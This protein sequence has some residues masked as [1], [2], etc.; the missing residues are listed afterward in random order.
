LVVAA[1]AQGRS[2]LKGVLDSRDTQVMLESLRALGLQFVHDRD[3]ATVEIEG[4]HG[5]PRTGPV[6]L[7]LENSGTSLRFLTAVCCLGYGR[8]RLDGNARMR[9]RPIG[10][11][12]EALCQWGVEARCEADNDCPPVNITATG[13]PAGNLRVKAD[14]SSQFASALLMVA[15]C[16]RSPVLLEIEGQVVSAPY[17]E[18]SLRVMKDFGVDVERE[19]PG[20]FRI[21]PQPYLGR[22]YDIEPDASSASY[23]FAAAAVT[24]GRVTVEGLSRDSLQ[25]DLRFVSV[26]SRMGCQVQ[27]GAN[28]VTVAGGPLR[29]VDIDMGPIS[30]TA[31]TLAAVACFAEGPTRIRNVGHMRHKETDRIAALVA[32]LTRIGQRVEEHSDGLTIYPAPIA[33]ATIETYADH[34]MAMSFALVGLRAPGIRIADP[35]CTAKT[36]PRFFEDLRL[37]RGQV[38]RPAP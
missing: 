10:D 19:G 17:I 28:E 6:V 30:D 11:L 16:A 5:R 20:R 25:G 9:E 13:L 26:L 22:L 18:M 7:W 1:L 37:L 34:R 3:A 27:F 32:E 36:Y 2:I 29:G 23:F 21:A 14:I 24:G 35:G 31:P 4:C 33:P 12:V 38:A 8:Y 15:P